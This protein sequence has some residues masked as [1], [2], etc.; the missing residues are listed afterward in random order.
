MNQE[1]WLSV[2]AFAEAAE[3]SPQAA[4]AAL[5]AALAGRAW[6][7]ERL[8][9]RRTLGRG[10]RGGLGC[11]VALVSLPPA[12]LARV[13]NETD[14]V[15]PASR[16]VRT[17][18]EGALAKLSALDAVLTQ[19]AGSAARN[20]AAQ[21][22]AQ[23]ELVSVRTIYRWVA[24]YEQHGVRGLGRAC[25]STAAEPRIVISRAF[26][27]ALRDA[28]LR[29]E[30][31]QTLA[32]E[33]DKALKGLWAS[34]AEQAGVTEVRRLA[35]FLLSE[36]CERRGVNLPPT[37]LRL[38]R[39]RVERFAHYRVVNQRRNDRKAYDDATPRIRRDWTGLAPME[40]VVADVKHLDVIVTRP[41]GSPAWPKIVAFMDA[42][43]GRVFV[44]P[45]LLERGE[46]VRQEHVIEGFLAMVSQPGWGFPQGLYLDNGSEF[47]ALVK[48]DSALQL[49]NEP[50]ARTLI[51][52][53]PYNAS[54][55]PIESLFARLDRYVF[56]LLPGY[57][58]PNRMA[59]KTQTVGKPPKPFPGT[60]EEFCATLQDLIGAHNLRPVGGPWAGRS[61]QDWFQDKVA[62]GWRPASVDPLALDA[63]FADQ[64]SRR[65]D[66]GVLKINGRRY[67]HPRLAALPSRTVVDLALP[68]RRDAEPLARIDGAWVYL[69]REIAYPARWVEGARESGRRQKAQNQH[70]SQLA[71]DAPAIDP[72]AAKIRWSKRLA[73]EPTPA[74]ARAKLDLGG[75]VRER[76]RSIRPPAIDPAQAPSPSP[77]E[78]RRAREMALTERLE[79]EQRGDD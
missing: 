6:R 53:R 21:R 8:Q 12:V 31:L 48:I 34:R 52:A 57:A 41:D 36:I 67:T 79:R 64:D 11:E 60:W 14:A 32:A 5:R 7:G 3:I 39:R 49:L 24:R 33:L 69:E 13:A 59:K 76:A 44:H 65:V 46:G 19:A 23:D 75:E 54:A 51:F 66:R 45:V 56:G 22:A 25:A 35:E 47:G 4:R 68:W 18:D 43:T 40:R 16:T 73:E 50:G 30:D 28:G 2:S 70:V 77:A 29:E 17:S 42:G 15:A 62:A 1:T 9:V 55:K 27:R 61:P 78:L 58:G 74:P 37:A 71:R 63:A 10:G 20:I 72:V 38:S 26:D